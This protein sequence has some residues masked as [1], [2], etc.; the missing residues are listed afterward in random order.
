M[1]LICSK[2]P[3]AHNKHTSLHVYLTRMENR[4]IQNW[5]PN[6]SNPTLPLDTF[7]KTLFLW[8]SQPRISYRTLSSLEITQKEIE[9]MSEKRKQGWSISPRLLLF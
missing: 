6:G 8:Y 2:V 3:Q 9:H 4:G 5:G 1:N 7:A